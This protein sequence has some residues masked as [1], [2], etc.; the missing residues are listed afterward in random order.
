MEVFLRKAQLKLNDILNTISEAYAPNTIRAYRADFEELIVFCK[1][2]KL[3]ALPAKRATVA[4]F[5][6]KVANTNITSA[7]IRRKLV[8]IAAIHRWSNFNDP[9]K[10]PEVKL[11]VRKMH[12]KLGRLCAQSEPINKDRLQ[13]MI[14]A[15]QNDLRGERDRTLLMLAY[16]T[17]RR[18]SELSSLQISDIRATNNRVSILL[19]K[20]KTDQE[21]LGTW[22]VI[23]EQTFKQIQKWINYA[24]ISNG[25]I[26]RGVQGNSKITNGLTG[27]QIAR[28]FKKIA[29]SAGI[30]QRTV[31]QISGHSIRIGAA[32][33]LLLTGASLPQIMTKGGW[34]KVD[35][36]MRYVE[37]TEINLLNFCD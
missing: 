11:A 13:I 4:K 35:N 34:S 12:R 8:S 2:N 7:S 17:M 14:S 10:S 32:Q 33:D 6:D 29:I 26:L 30:D 28:I 31:S 36:V 37:K 16:D 21:R 22:L 3:S 25:K 5:I 24:K 18:R 1:E 20:S 15:T 9:T 19:R 23:T 27:A